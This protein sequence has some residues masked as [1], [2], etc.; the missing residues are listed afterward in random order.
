MKRLKHVKQSF[1]MMVLYG[2]NYIY[3]YIYFKVFMHVCR[4]LTFKYKD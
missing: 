4:F 3:I 1:K 2:S